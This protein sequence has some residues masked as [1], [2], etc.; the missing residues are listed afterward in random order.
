MGKWQFI[1]SNWNIFIT[2]KTSKIILIHLV[3]NFLKN[4]RTIF[5]TFRRLNDAGISCSNGTDHCWK[6]SWKWII[7]TANNKCWSKRLKV[8]VDFCRE[9]NKRSFEC[10]FGHPFFEV[11]KSVIYFKIGDLNFCEKSMVR[12]L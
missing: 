7:P 1:Q 10:F 6:Y 9:E 3:N 5:R 11:F 2:L 4:L 8:F 12:I